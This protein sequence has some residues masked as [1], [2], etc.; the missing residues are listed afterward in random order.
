MVYGIDYDKEAVTYCKQKYAA[1]NIKYI[2]MDANSLD[3]DR[4]FDIAVTFRVIE[5]MP[6]LAKFVE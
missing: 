3:L 4:Q 5:H 1:P 2:E 6:N